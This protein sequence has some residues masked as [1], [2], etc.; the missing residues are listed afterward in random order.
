MFRLFL[1]RGLCPAADN[2]PKSTLLTLHPEKK[3]SKK[4]N[5]V[6]Q[7][8]VL[9][10]K[11]GERVPNPVSFFTYALESFWKWQNELMLI[12]LH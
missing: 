5:I 2:Y 7:Y 12:F 8:S 1:Y 4:V 3:R 10:K 6:D 9:S 11:I